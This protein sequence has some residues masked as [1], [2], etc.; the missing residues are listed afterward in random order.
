MVVLWGEVLGFES[1][2]VVVNA[3]DIRILHANIIGSFL[4]SQGNLRIM[5]FRCRRSEENVVIHHTLLHSHKDSFELGGVLC[6]SV[7]TPDS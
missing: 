7:S 2:V 1:R 3:N 6:L 5:Y 4:S